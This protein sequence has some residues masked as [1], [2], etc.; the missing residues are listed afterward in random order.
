M[1]TTRRI[2]TPPIRHRRIFISYKSTHEPATQ[3]P[4]TGTSTVTSV[5]GERVY[6]PPHLF[7]H[8]ISTTSKPLCRN[9]RLS[10]PINIPQ[11]QENPCFRLKTIQSLTPF[12]DLIDNQ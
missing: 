9:A 12:S 3:N 10:T 8:T 6:L 4:T 5:K 11:I 2:I 1:M 7:P